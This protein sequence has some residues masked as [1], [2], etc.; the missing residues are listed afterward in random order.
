MSLYCFYL[1]SILLFNGTIAREE[2]HNK[3]AQAA[4]LLQLKISV[5]GP[6]EAE[7]RSYKREEYPMR[8]ISPKHS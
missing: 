2:N 5:S 8:R 1:R 6:P 3:K 4:F 7:V